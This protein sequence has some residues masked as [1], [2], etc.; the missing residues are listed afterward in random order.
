MP[1]LSLSFA[2]AQV[3]QAIRCGR[4]YG[5]EIMEAT[6][7]PSGTV[8]PALRRMEKAAMIRSAW[9]PEAFARA[10]QRPARKYYKLTRPGDAALAAAAARYR[11]PDLAAMDASR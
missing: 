9:E 4:R 2:A 8:Y 10:E 5:F 3:L 1:E 11:L 6:G 7:L